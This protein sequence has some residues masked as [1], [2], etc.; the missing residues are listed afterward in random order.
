MCTT[1]SG[2]QVVPDIRS[3]QKKEQRNVQYLISSAQQ[4]KSWGR[5]SA[6]GF[7]LRVQSSCGMRQCR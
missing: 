5:S 3:N 1:E 7:V 2:Q 6:G 4:T